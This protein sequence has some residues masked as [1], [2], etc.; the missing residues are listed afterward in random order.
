VLTVDAWSLHPKQ[1][2]NVLSSFQGIDRLLVKS[3]YASRNNT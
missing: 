2:C 1:L 3:S